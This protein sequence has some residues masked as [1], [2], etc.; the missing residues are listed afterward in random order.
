MY[1]VSPP[2]DN[3]PPQP[4]LH[5][6]V[7]FFR[8]FFSPPDAC[9][10]PNTYAG[11]SW[12]QWRSVS[13]VFVRKVS[14]DV[15]FARNKRSEVNLQR[16]LKQRSRLLSGTPTQPS[17]KRP[18]RRQRSQEGE[19]TLIRRRKHPEPPPQ[20]LRVRVQIQ[21]RLWSRCGS[22]CSPACFV[23]KPAGLLVATA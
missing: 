22:A 15:H 20:T 2:V 18:A 1:V 12:R 4:Q 5:P 6:N 11:V 9:C 21:A 16:V 10:P 3:R 14:N 13:A 8:R 7:R 23:C 19:P 17:R